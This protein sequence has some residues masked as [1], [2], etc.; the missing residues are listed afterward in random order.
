[1]SYCLKY[2]CF[3]GEGNNWAERGD[4][5]GETKRSPSK[6]I[7]SSDFKNCYSDYIVS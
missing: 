2:I 7:V 6:T 4:E 3:K 5:E 1:M